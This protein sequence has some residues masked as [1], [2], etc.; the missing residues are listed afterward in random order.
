M[1]L[2]QFKSKSALRCP[3]LDFERVKG[4]RRISW[5]DRIQVK[6]IFTGLG[7]RS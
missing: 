3:V 2:P 1:L 5:P 7:R 4:M 6:M